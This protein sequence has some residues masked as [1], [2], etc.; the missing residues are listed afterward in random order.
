MPFETCTYEEGVYKRLEETV[1]E[2]MDED[3]TGK[4]VPH[5]KKAL[6]QELAE[7]RARVN[8]VESIM[9]SLFPGEGYAPTQFSNEG[10]AEKA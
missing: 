8:Q 3:M 2:Y 1:C 9:N 6:C 7:R 4:L 5:L 10:A